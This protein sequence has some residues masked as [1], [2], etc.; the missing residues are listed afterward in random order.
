MAAIEIKQDRAG[1]A[2]QVQR[3]RHTQGSAG[4]NL[5]FQV[6]EIVIWLSSWTPLESMRW[7]SPRNGNARVRS[8]ALG[9]NVERIVA[10][11]STETG[12]SIGNAA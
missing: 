7:S 6:T 11:I 2:R 9:Y 10:A 1:M 12:T 4:G 5:P 3:R 8:N